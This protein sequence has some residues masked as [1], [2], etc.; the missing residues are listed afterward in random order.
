MICMELTST[1]RCRFPSTVRNINFPTI[2]A[3]V[4]K[5]MAP[6]NTRVNLISRAGVSCT[7][8]ARTIPGLHLKQVVNKIS[9]ESQNFALKNFSTTFPSFRDVLEEPTKLLCCAFCW[10]HR[11]NKISYHVKIKK[12]NKIASEMVASVVGKN[13]TQSKVDEFH[14]LL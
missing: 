6:Q 3:M 9:Y 14:T 11:W 1:L 13:L 7:W 4:G 5:N 12:E 10:C 8:V 2:V